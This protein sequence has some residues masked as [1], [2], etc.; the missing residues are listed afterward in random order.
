MKYFIPLLLCAACTSPS[1]TESVNPIPTPPDTPSV[2]LPYPNASTPME[3]AVN[4]CDT[5]DTYT[6]LFYP[7]REFLFLDSAGTLIQEFN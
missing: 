7:D 1:T 3:H 2:K 4:M 5:S 6:I